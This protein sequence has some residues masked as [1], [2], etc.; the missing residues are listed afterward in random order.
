MESEVHQ[1]S[2]ITVRSTFSLAPQTLPSF[3]S[4]PPR[5]HPPHSDRHQDVPARSSQSSNIS[6]PGNTGF[7]FRAGV[8]HICLLLDIYA[9]PTVTES[10]ETRHNPL[11]TVGGLC[12]VLRLFRGN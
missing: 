10:Y 1:T 4:I 7:G 9:I 5:L 12:L 2:C 11:P 6:D 3:L 8:S